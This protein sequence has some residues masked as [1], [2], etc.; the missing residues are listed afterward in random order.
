LKIKLYTHDT[1]LE[2]DTGS[3]HPEHSGRLKSVLDAA[4]S[5][6]GITIDKDIMEA[7]RELLLLVHDEE[8]I[9]TI[10]QISP[11]S[12][13]VYADPDTVISPVS[14]EAARRAAGAVCKAVDDCASGTTERAFC[15]VRPPGH[16]A[17]KDRSM[18]FCLFNNIS[19]SAMHALNSGFKRV[20]IVDFD[21]HHGNGTHQVAMKHEGIFLISSHQWP[22]FP[23]T[24]RAEDNIEGRVL[25]I[26]L[27]PGSGSGEFREVYQAKVFPALHEYR[28]DLLFISA[29]FDGHRDDPL[30]GLELVEEDYGWVTGELAKIADRYCEG[31]IISVLEGGYDLEALK[32][33]V[34]AHFQALTN[35]YLSSRQKPGSGR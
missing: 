8:Y 22:L 1:F 30:A 21:V 18:G 2:H 13:Y 6:P 31:K 32:K 12:G 3:G 4:G 33:S 14:L 24:G 9:D 5:I 28:P 26:P 35:S 15:A 23:G 25:N 19:I 29:G 20:A 34:T 16:H 7:G 11:R 27:T 17:E 10:E